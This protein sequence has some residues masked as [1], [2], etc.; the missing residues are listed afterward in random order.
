MD[1]T[2][3]TDQPVTETPPVVEAAPE[4]APAPQTVGDRVNIEHL[5]LGLRS[6]ETLYKEMARIGIKIECVEVYQRAWYRY[7]VTDNGRI[8]A[9]MFHNCHHLSTSDMVAVLCTGGQP[10]TKRA[11]EWL[12]PK[13]GLYLGAW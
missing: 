10:Y 13:I 9:V 1:Q 8:V 12:G 7:T 11:R 3:A 4:P 5:T 6:Y 2:T